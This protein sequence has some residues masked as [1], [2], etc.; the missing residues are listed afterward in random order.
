MTLNAP[1]FTPTHKSNALP[2]LRILGLDAKSEVQLVEVLAAGLEPERAERLAR[3]LDLSLTRLLEL[4]GIKS[5]TYH[6]RKKRGRPLSSEE[7][8]RI[9]RLAKLA[10]AAEAYFEDK[11]AARRWLEHPK[12][13]L[14]GKSPL[15]FG[16]TAEG[17]AYVLALL[18]R[19]AHGVI[20]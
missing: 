2:G 12:V 5:S 20:S 19:M 15:A 7:S 11:V 17:A 16:R 18:G 9:Y 4:A 13:A 6:D 3:H 1:I 14:G 10:E 8:E